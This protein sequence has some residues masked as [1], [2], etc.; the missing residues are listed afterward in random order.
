MCVCSRLGG[1]CTETCRIFFLLKYEIMGWLQFVALHTQQLWQ[2]CLHLGFELGTAPK[3]GLNTG[4]RSSELHREPQEQ[5]RGFSLP[6]SGILCP[7]QNICSTRVVAQS[8][9]I[10]HLVVYTEHSPHRGFNI[11]KGSQTTFYF[12]F[13]CRRCCLFV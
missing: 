6:T 13:C 1:V 3:F 12:I 10:L 5:S 7:L 11:H 9:V 2:S 8:P 4:R